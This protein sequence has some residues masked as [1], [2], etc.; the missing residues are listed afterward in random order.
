VNDF[1]RAQGEQDTQPPADDFSS[2][3]EMDYIMTENES[4][5][6]KVFGSHIILLFKNS[7]SLLL[8]FA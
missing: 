4:N 3:D 6:E 7:A 2:H 5:L 8:G 1:N